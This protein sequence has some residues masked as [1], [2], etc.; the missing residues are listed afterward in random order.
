ME[1]VVGGAIGE[2]ADDGQ[3]H[4]L[5]RDDE[6]GDVHPRELGVPAEGSAQG[7]GAE[8]G[9]QGDRRPEP[10]G[11]DRD[12]ERVAAGAGHELRRGPPRSGISARDG[13]QIDDQFAQDAQLRDRCGHGVTV[14][15]HVRGDRVG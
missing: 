11:G 5:V 10:A 15:R 13:Q 2:Q 9:D 1:A 14:G 12:V 8:P 3:A 7:A 6:A 4:R